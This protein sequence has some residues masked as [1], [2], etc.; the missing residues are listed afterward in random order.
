MNFK[1]VLTLTLMLLVCATMLNAKITMKSGQKVDKKAKKNIRSAKMYYNQQNW[2]KL[3]P[4]LDKALEVQ[5]DNM[6]ALYYLAEMNFTLAEER[7][8]KAKYY[9]AARDYY[10]KLYAAM[11]TPEYRLTKGKKKTN[12]EEWEKDVYLKAKSSWIRVFNAAINLGKEQRYDEAIQI[13]NTLAEI[14]PDSAQIYTAL[15]SFYM[16]SGREEEGL[17]LLV[18]IA[19]K[20]PNNTRVLM[21]IAIAFYNAE[22]FAKAAEYYEKL[23]QADPTNFDYAFNGGVAYTQAQNDDKALVMYELA[24]KIDAQNVTVIAE[25]ARI[26]SNKQDGAKAIEFYAKAIVI[27]PDNIDNY[28]FLVYQAART[29]DWNNVYTYAKQWHEKDPKNAEPVQFLYASTDKS[30]LNKKD[31]NKKYQKL[32]MEL[33]Q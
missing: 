10:N 19:E 32:F 11:Q 20:N 4:L 1:K 25:I 15:S 5:P 33:S 6:I 24:H 18:D 26:A 22:N 8:D 28:Q 12:Y 16:S 14:T 13:T 29:K 31:E 23:N 21:Q 27:E 2:E 9:L 7:K 30:A 3:T 17:K